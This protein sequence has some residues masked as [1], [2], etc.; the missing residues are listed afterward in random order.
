MVYIKGKNPSEES[1]RHLLLEE[2]KLLE[3]DES[4]PSEFIL[5]ALCS[6]ESTWRQF[7]YLNGMPVYGTP[8]GYGLMQIDVPE[9]KSWNSILNRHRRKP[10]SEIEKCVIEELREYQRELM[11]NWKTNCVEGR[12]SYNNKLK[13]SKRYVLS[14][15]KRYG[16]NV[17]PDF[18]LEQYERNAAYLYRGASI[19]D[20]KAQHYYFWNQETKQWEKNPLADSESV[21]HADKVMRVKY[22]LETSG[23]P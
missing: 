18:T 3:V 19:V 12:E 8:G 14:V 16:A 2:A 5:L 1:L 6:A 11:W 4:K 10:P 21:K 17:V 20:R 9:D 22:N 23:Q 15:R 13:A 7:Y